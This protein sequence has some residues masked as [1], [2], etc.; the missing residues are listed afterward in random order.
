MTEGH[1][2]LS[3]SHLTRA[4]TANGTRRVLVDDISYSFACGTVYSVV[5]PSGAGKSSL[6]RLINRLDEPDS[7]EVRYNDRDYRE[8]SPQ[9]LRRHIG[10][11][12]QTPYLFP[13][14]V[15]ENLRFAEASLT[16]SQIAGLLDQVGLEPGVASADVDTLSGGEKQRI[17]MARLL[18]TQPSVILLD[19]PTSS[20]DP[21]STRGIEKL[22]KRIAEERCL[23]AIMVTHEPEQAVRL[24]GETLL[25]V[26]GRLVEH[27]PSEQVL[28]DPQSDEGRRY[29][30]MELS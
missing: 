29:K 23:V 3:L 26:K 24:G 13:G 16:D 18:A 21:T 9:E 19:E 22:I 15:S 27:G 20:L 12:F 14:T 30:G 17:A 11:L 25:L 10:Y 2:T 7:G 8:L 28:N 4:I 1:T 5:G 6:L